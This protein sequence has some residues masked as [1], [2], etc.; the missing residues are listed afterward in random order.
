M[1]TVNLAADAEIARGEVIAEHRSKRAGLRQTCVDKLET[2]TVESA[3]D[4]VR[5]GPILVKAT[6]CLNLFLVDV[7]VGKN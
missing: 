5:I 1:E 6:V 2:Q 7:M 4:A 3:D